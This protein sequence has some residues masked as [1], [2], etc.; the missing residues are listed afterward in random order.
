MSNTINIAVDGYSST[1]KSTLARQLAKKLGYRYI[2]TGAM[3]RAVTLWAIDHEQIFPTHI[4]PEFTSKLDQIDLNFQV[5]P[6]GGENILVMN[7]EA[8]GD[9]LRSMAVSKLVSKVA[10]LGPVRRY[11]VAEQQKIAAA[12]GVVMDGRDIGSVVIPDAELKIFVTAD[13]DVRAER[14]YKELTK[15]GE[16]VTLQQV[17]QNLDER[18]RLDTSRSDSPLVRAEG[19]YLLD[20]SQMDVEG[21]LKIALQWAV[22]AITKLPA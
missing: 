21:Q 18:D 17:A 13:L 14:R 7:G 15:K 3:Y 16:E 5:D 10:A 22:E 12:K 20:N 1:G 6:E 9:K 2:D 4:D 19:S 8:P 11:L